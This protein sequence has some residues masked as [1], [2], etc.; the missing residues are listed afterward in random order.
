MAYTPSSMEGELEILSIHII[1]H[2]VVIFFAVDVCHAGVDIVVGD[3]AAILVMHG[4]MIAVHVCAVVYVVVVRGRVVAQADVVLGGW[5]LCQA[6]ERFSV[7]AARFMLDMAE[8]GFLVGSGEPGA[9]GR[10]VRLVGVILRR[11]RDL[12]LEV[13]GIWTRCQQLRDEQT[14]GGRTGPDNLRPGHDEVGRAR[15]GGVQRETAGAPGGGGRVVGW[16]VR[17]DGNGLAGRATVF[18]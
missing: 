2:A 15:V 14:P 3:G 4:L 11:G 9:Q 6:W 7:S 18:V 1:V 12:V 10:S 8:L 5:R 13:D 16:L 17:R